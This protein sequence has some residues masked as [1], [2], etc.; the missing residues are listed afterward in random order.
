MRT[1][2]ILAASVL[3]AG[4][5]FVLWPSAAVIPGGE[6]R[7]SLTQARS[8]GAR[9]RERAA[10]LDRQARSA[11]QAGERATIAAA[12]LG[13]RVQ[14]AEAALAGADAEM[15]LLR[16][17]RRAL[18]SRLAK[19]RAPVTQ[20]LAGLQTQ[21]RRPSLLTLLQ[22]GSITDAVHL[23]AALAAVGPQIAART[24]SLRTALA[25]SRRLENEAART[26]AERRRLGTELRARRL[27]LAALS[28]AER[29]K[30]QR[31]AGAAD[32]EAERAYTLGLQARDL[33]T[34]VRR[35]D[36]G[37]PSPRSAPG[38]GRSDGPTP[39]RLPA[40]GSLEPPGTT[41]N[42]GVSLLVQPGALVV[43]PGTGRVAFAGPFRGYGAIVIIEHAGGWASL[44]TGLAATQVVVGQKV[45]PGSPLGQAPPRNPRIGLELSRNGRRVDPLDQ[46]HDGR[47]R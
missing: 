31:A 37:E 32:R 2:A 24:G 11:M 19:E 22:P 1:R 39:Y 6:A 25:R 3:L 28:A 30:A 44:V 40:A 8:E 38:A 16:E 9:A 14:Q 23:R 34:L 13:A 7:I 45:I 27:E 15:A 21:V 5:A 46:L 26:V 17:Q 20:L 35:L 4:G 33:T 18:D 42:R 36:T 41:R 12:A 29:L 47:P 10:A 43:A